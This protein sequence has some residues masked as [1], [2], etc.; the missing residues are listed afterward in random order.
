MVDHLVSFGPYDISTIDAPHPK[1]DVVWKLYK[2]IDLQLPSCLLVVR[3]DT[4]HAVEMIQ[5]VLLQAEDHVDQPEKHIDVRTE[6]IAL[7]D[8]KV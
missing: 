7:N 4:H 2:I 5:M 1:A 3:V 8:L 6:H